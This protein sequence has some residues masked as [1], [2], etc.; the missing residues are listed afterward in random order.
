MDSPT[1]HQ[2]DTPIMFKS[3]SEMWFLFGFC[4]TQL[5]LIVVILS[6]QSGDFVKQKQ[7][8]EALRTL[9]MPPSTVI[10]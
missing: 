3:S 2:K 7:Q 5:T 9:T 10:R 8:R 1:Q 6:T 4:I